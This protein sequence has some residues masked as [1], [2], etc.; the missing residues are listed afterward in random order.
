MFEYYGNLHVYCTGVGANEPLGSNSMF[1][2]ID[3]QSY[4]LF[5]ARFSLQMA[6]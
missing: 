6:F 3:I 2:I 5:P 1:R 4:C